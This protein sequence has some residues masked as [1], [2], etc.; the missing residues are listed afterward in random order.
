[1]QLA[2][3]NQMKLSVIIP[4]YNEERTLLEVVSK[5]KK[6]SLDK[7]I[8]I[9]ND[10]STDRTAEIIETIKKHEKNPHIKIL[11]HEK[12]LGKGAAV[13][14]GLNNATGDIVL[15]Q[16]AD[17]EYEP[18]DYKKLIEPII[19]KGASVVYGTRIFSLSKKDMHTLHYFGNKIL[20]LIT[21]LLYGCKISDMETCYKIFKKDVLKGI[22][23]RSRGF[24]FEPEITAKLLKNGYKIYEVPI[25]FK[26]RTFD[27]GKKITW[28]DGVKAVY[29]LIK[30]RFV[31]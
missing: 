27:E 22:T 25:V 12:N 10:G 28:R 18:A 21:N 16:D 13:R 29:Y 2:K 20:T 3:K 7:E 4:V 30:Y 23:L 9:V 24:E 19:N 14:T 6:V 26:P 15:I 17:L 1:M 8:I 31:D 11:Q 5:V